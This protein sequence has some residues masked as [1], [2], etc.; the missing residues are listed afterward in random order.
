MATELKLKDNYLRPHAEREINEEIRVCESQLGTSNPLE[1][2]VD[3]RKVAQRK[4]N[5]E[6]DLE[7]QK[8][9][10]LSAAELDVVAK[11]QKEL[12]DSISS[13]MPTRDMMM[14]NPSG[15]VG[16]NINFEKKHKGNILRWK[17][18]Q[19]LLNRGS[20]DP[21]VANAER[22]R[23][24]GDALLSY[25]GAQIPRKAEYSIA[26]PQ[27]SENYDEVNWQEKMSSLE[28][29]IVSVEALEKK[30]EAA[31][32]SAKPSRKS[33]PSTPK[34]LAHHQRMRDKAKAKREGSAETPHS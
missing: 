24:G 1:V 27:F 16:Y 20:D 15:A 5:L 6:R 29:K 8:P 23:P 22:L 7:E 33:R 19:V 30:L 11:D 14:R 2:V 13:E 3:R 4:R 10:D 9:P 31:I 26:S 32:K 34:E 17:R 21:D 18:N 12:S 25:A 28:A